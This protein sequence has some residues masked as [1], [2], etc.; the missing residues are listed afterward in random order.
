M[1]SSASTSPFSCVPPFSM[2][3]VMRSNISIGG[4]G[5]RAFPSPN[6]S[7]RAQARRP[8]RSKL[9]LRPDMGIHPWFQPALDKNVR[10]ADLVF[11][12]SIL[13]GERLECAFGNDEAR[14]PEAQGL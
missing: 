13:T 11:V 3:F 9:D 2:I 14:V 8:G 1:S 5:R 7:P 10:A 4:S 12:R 6:N